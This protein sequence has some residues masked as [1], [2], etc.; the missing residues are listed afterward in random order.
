[1][2]D[3][4][5]STGTRKQKLLFKCISRDQWPV[6]IS[7]DAPE[8]GNWTLDGALRAVPRQLPQGGMEWTAQIELPLGHT[9]EYKFVKHSDN[10]PRWESGSNH[11]ITVIPGLH[12]IDV[13]FRD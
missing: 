2:T 9:I 5:L 11:R 1:M 8:L 12:A 7:G 10:G 4:H 13:D 6:V 3:S